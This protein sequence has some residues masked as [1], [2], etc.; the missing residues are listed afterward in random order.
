MKKNPIPIKPKIQK[1]LDTSNFDEKLREISVFGEQSYNPL[2]NHKYLYTGN[3]YRDQLF[4]FL[5]IF[6]L[7]NISGYSFAATDI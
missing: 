6:F 5:N 1:P 7:F 4:F 3:L 2:P